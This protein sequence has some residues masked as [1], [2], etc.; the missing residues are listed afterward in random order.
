MKDSASNSGY[1]AEAETLLQRYESF[2]CEEV[3]AHW[4]DW[5]PQPPADLLDIGAGTGRDAAWLT[6]LGYRVVAVEPTQALREGAQKLHPEPEITWLDSR[7]PDLPEVVAR[8]QQF[9][10][11]MLNAVWMHLEQHERAEG[12]GTLAGLMRPGA[13]LFMSL[14]HGPVPE[15]R[16]MFDVT[17]DET[18]ALAATYRMRP[19]YE[20]RSGSILAENRNAGIEWTCLVL[21]MV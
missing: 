2:D 1:A 18:I 15:G 13:R 4:R 9:D 7:L 16:R 14:R 11:V 12:M 19:L 10:M 17:G 20:T 6:S 8:G 21:E 3:H 5:F